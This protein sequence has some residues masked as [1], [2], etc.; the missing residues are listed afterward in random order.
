MGVIANLR[1]Y[2]RVLRGTRYSEVPQLVRILRR[3]P[4]IALGVSVYETGLM[5]SGRVEG[6]LKALAAVKASSLIGCPF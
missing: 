6:R 4:A 2:A 3:R 1:A 5:M